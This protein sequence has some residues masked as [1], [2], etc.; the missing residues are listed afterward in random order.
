MSLAEQHD[1]EESRFPPEI[2]AKARADL[3]VSKFA[4]NSPWNKQKVEQL[5][6]LAEE[7]LSCSVIGS[8]LGVTRNSVIGR[9]HRMGLTR[10][11]PEVRLA[12]AGGPRTSDGRPRR[13]GTATILRWRPRPDKFKERAAAIVPLNIELQD[14]DTLHCR[15][16]YGDSPFTFCGHKKM[17]GSSYCPDHFALTW[18]PPRDRK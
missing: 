4:P 6:K 2:L 15:F 18:A 11:R 1:A 16:P 8:L 12:R 3:E 14:L 7:G 17:E 5:L 9:L 13:D 10:P